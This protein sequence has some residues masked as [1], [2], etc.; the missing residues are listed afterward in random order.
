MMQHKLFL[1][2]RGNICRKIM[3]SLRLKLFCSNHSE[4]VFHSCLEIIKL[5]RLEQWCLML[6]VV[7]SGLVFRPAEGDTD[8]VVKE[9]VM[10]CWIGKSFCCNKAAAVSTFLPL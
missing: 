2:E 4:K 7:L 6:C 3:L 1:L 9:E 5:W 10:L 8:S